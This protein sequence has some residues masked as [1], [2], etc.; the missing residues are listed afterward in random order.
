MPKSRVRLSYRYDERDN[1]TPQ[2]TWERVIADSFLSGDPETNIPYSFERSNLS[3]SADYDLFRTLKISAGYDRKQIDRDFQEVAEQTEDGGWG[4]LRWRPLEVVEID[5]TGGAS[6][7][8]IDRYNETV[9]VMF[10]QN[11]LLR[12]YNLAYR[13]REYADLTVTYTPTQAPI[14][15]TINA[16]VADD[17]YT[18]SQLGITDGEELRVYADLSWAISDN[19]SLYLTAGMEDIESN[20]LG[21]QGFAVAD[22]SATHDD[23][24][25]TYGIGF[26]ARQITDKLDLKFDYNRSDGE[27][28]ITVSPIAASTSEFPE[29]TSELDNLRLRLT[30]QRSDRLEIDLDLRYQRFVAEDWALEGVGPATI[31]TVLTLGPQPYSP[32]VISIGI[33][34]RYTIGDNN[35]APD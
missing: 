2:A 18:Q 19:S 16:L 8:D 22:W 7:R 23:D 17:S 24:F 9:A 31:P 26:R 6:K 1:S 27:S 25:T 11:P 32:E 34:F 21:S 10:D 13:Y 33:G 29:L 14:S 35:S 28:E 3:L 30:Y 20:Q 15:L 5:V 12:K 4:R